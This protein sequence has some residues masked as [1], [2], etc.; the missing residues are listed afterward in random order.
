M[1][2][3]KQLD[4]PEA[5]I[6]QA[7]ENNGATAINAPTDFTN[8]A[9]SADKI[10]TAKPKINK[11]SNIAI[12]GFIVSLIGYISSSTLFL[13][14]GLIFSVIGIPLVIARR[15]EGLGFALAGV[16]VA[17]FKFFALIIT[18]TITVSCL[19]LLTLPALTESNYMEL[20][21]YLK[22]LGP[23]GYFDGYSYYDIPT[24]TEY[25]VNQILSSVRLCAYTL[26]VRAILKT[27]FALF[28]SIIVFAVWIWRI[29]CKQF[30]KIAIQK[31]HG[32]EAHSFA[33]CFWFGII[34]TIYV[35]ALPDRNSQKTIEPQKNE[36]ETETEQSPCVKEEH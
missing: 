8:R 1:E 30:E 4:A 21:E 5:G 9:Q 13:I 36:F 26:F 19:T 18:G 35:L 31:G 3:V 29:I 2:S 17:V 24:Y 16:I 14:I 7:L 15:Y 32:K 27:I 33:M 34:G 12:L 10:K 20:C 28:M 25:V 11:F 22:S 23:Y 6:T